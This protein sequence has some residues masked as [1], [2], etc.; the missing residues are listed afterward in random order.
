MSGFFV[1]G[2]MNCFVVIVIKRSII[3]SLYYTAFD[4]IVNIIFL[5]KAN[6]RIFLIDRY[7]NFSYHLSNFRY[8]GITSGEVETLPVWR[9]FEP[10]NKLYMNITVIPEGYCMRICRMRRNIKTSV[11]TIRCQF[12]VMSGGHDL[13]E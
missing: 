4:M 5:Q 10:F 9:W 13:P 8:F 11:F 3:Q 7:K 2:Y 6:V 12:R 1:C